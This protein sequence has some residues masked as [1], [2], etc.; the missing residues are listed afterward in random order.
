MI[1]EQAHIDLEPNFSSPAMGG[2]PRGQIFV[3]QELIEM[4]IDQLVGDS[5]SLRHCSLVSRKWTPRC[6]YQLLRFVVISDVSPA[7]SIECWSN[8]FGAFNGMY[9]SARMLSPSRNVWYFQR[10]SRA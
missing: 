6:R 10:R 1:K 9:L 2:P 7:H 3:S 8:T 5:G 4:I